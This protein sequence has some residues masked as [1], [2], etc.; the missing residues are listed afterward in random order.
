M[1]QL[2]RISLAF[3]FAALL[4]STAARAQVLVSGVNS[5]NTTTLSAAQTQTQTY[6]VVASATGFTTGDALYIDGEVEIIGLR[7]PYPPYATYAGGTTVP[8]FRTGSNGGAQVGAHVSGAI[9]VRGLP[10]YFNAFNPTG[11][12][13]TPVTNGGPTPAQVPTSPWV[14][15]KT[16][17]IFR[18]YGTPAQWGKTG[19]FFVPA[20]QCNWIPT[21][22]TQTTTFPVVG[23][24]ATLFMP[25][26]NSVTSAAAGTDT[27]SCWF[28]APA[29]VASLRTNLLTD[30]TVSLGSQVVAPTSIGTATLT[31]ILFP[32]PIATTQT[33]TTQT[34]TAAAGGAVTQ[35][36][37]TTTVLTITTAGD[38]LT[39]NYQFAAPVDLTPDLRMLNFTLPILQSAA[40]AMTLNTAGLWVHYI[41]RQ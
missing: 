31:S 38:F 12:C 19:V 11:A 7:L 6:L 29:D 28:V 5:F 34:V 24:G 32:T 37:P 39:F 41:H 13:P 25:V 36:G 2:T 16:G 35:I 9:V 17:D 22:L 26:S 15:T 33:A 21:T 18:C 23:L 20:I 40:S 14:N 30:I 1:K 8:V 3:A 27:L 4:F 10:R